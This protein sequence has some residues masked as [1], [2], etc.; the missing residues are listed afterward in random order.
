MDWLV[1]GLVLFLGI[2]SVSIAAPRWRH[3]VAHRIGEGPWKGLYTLVA[4][5]GFGLI[6]AGYSAA[7]QNPVLLWTPPVAMRHVAAVLMLPVFVL[8]LSAYLPGRIQRAAKHPML[9]ATKLWAL[10]HL[11]ANGGLA[12]VV[13]FGAFLAWAVA[14]RVS[15]KRRASAGLLRAPHTFGPGKAN[16]AIALVGGLLLY[17]VFAFW[18]HGFLIGVRPFG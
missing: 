7:R 17:V 5:A 2:H 13:L 6:V 16:D 1:L 11:L 3:A 10:A 9:A 15:L 8:L 4:L 12:D 14:D 18:A